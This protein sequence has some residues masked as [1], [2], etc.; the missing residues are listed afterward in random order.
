MVVDFF[1]APRNRILYN[2]IKFAD[3]H[4]A[5][6]TKTVVRSC[7][8]AQEGKEMNQLFGVLVILIGMLLIFSNLYHFYHGMAFSVPAVV[9]GGVIALFGGRLLQGSGSHTV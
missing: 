8:D 7:G 6:V 2:N 3:G 4:D 5:R 9:I 1:I